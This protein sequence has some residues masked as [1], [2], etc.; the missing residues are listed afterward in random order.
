MTTQSDRIE[1]KVLLRAP[2]ARVWTAVSDAQQFGTWF[3]MTLDGQFEAGRRIKGRISPTKV[4]AEVAKMQEPWAGMACDFHVER[5]EPMDHFSFRWHPGAEEAGPD[6]TAE[7]V[8]R[9]TRGVG[10]DAV[11]IATPID[12]R[13]II[14]LD[15]PAYRARYDL[16]V[17]SSPSLEDVLKERLGL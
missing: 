12:L 16:A 9:L 5:V 3:G 2:L 14:D 13:K 1:K 8:L 11:L 6:L 17:T 4:D 10:V 15:K 7:Q